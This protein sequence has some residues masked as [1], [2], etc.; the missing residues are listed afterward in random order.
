MPDAPILLI[1]VLAAI[2][3]VV[4]FV[5][6]TWWRGAKLSLFLFAIVL[7]ALAFVVYAAQRR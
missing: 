6:R 5:V 3:L 7:F 2:C 1:A 4:S